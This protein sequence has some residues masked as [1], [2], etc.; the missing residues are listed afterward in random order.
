[1]KIDELLEIIKW[2]N[3]CRSYDASKEYFSKLDFIIISS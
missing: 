2:L 1:M 3:N